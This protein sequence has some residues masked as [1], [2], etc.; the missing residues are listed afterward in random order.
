VWEYL[1]LLVE[2]DAAAG[3]MTIFFALL[4]CIA[5]GLVL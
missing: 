4:A 3:V 2:Q 1:E 5:V